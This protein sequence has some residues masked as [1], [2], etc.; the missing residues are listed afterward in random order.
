[1]TNKTLTKKRRD[2]AEEVCYAVILLMAL[3]FLDV[4][5]AERKLLGEPMQVW[6]NLAEETG[7]LPKS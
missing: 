1:M 4:P 7:K 2:A 6:A 3:G 5:D